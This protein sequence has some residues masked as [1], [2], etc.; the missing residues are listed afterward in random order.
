MHYIN[1]CYFTFSCNIFVNIYTECAL[2][3]VRAEA[4]EAVD[5]VESEIVN[6]D[7]R[8]MASNITA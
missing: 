5:H 7:N 3:N 6:I 2:R 4:E 8:Y 1:T